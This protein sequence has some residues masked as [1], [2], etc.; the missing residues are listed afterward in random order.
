MLTNTDP[1]DPPTARPAARSARCG[2]GLRAGA[3]TRH[4]RSVSRS[5]TP[6]GRSRCTAAGKVL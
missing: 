5:A 4:R 2:P 3:E 1:G 6:P